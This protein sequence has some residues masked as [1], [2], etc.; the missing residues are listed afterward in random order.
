MLSCSFH[1]RILVLSSGP[2]QLWVCDGQSPFLPHTLPKHT[3]KGLLHLFSNCSHF[4]PFALI[5][6]LSSENLFCGTNPACGLVYFLFVLGIPTTWW[7][8]FP[9]ILA[10]PFLWFITKSCF[11]SPGPANSSSYLPTPFSPL[12]AHFS[13]PPPHT[14]SSLMDT[15]EQKRTEQFSL[16]FQF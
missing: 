7:Q 6:T 4:D 9:R 14:L 10:H 13:C 16:S 8:L 1:P 2:S 11:E 12:L 3:I 5:Q 15:R